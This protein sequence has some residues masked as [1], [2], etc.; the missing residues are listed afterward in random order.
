MPG[1]T[2][3]GSNDEVTCV[4]DT[5]FRLRIA[6][7]YP[8]VMNIYG[9]RGNVLALRYRCEARGIAVEVTDVT[10]GDDFDPAAVDIVVIGGGQDREQRRI[11]EDLAG[12]GA[13]LRRAV[14]DGMP[15]LAV[16]GGFQL[17]GREYVGQDGEA[18][19]GIGVFD[20]E[21]RH[22]GADVQRCIGDVVLATDEGEVVGF[23]NHGGRTYLR[24]GQA[25]FGKVVC[26]YGNNAEDGQEGARTRNAIGTYL[27][28]S[29]LPKNPA[30]TDELILAALKR[31]YGEQA[32]L[33]PL[34]DA[35][36]QAAH[37]AAVA[38]ARRSQGGQKAR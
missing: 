13:A 26:G 23:E 22:A 27:H 34:D 24:P 31:R 19:T 14:D 21:T 9:D 16:C 3:P 28:G 30:L 10:V 32:T 33:A 4:D 2:Y 15:V 25:A 7:L 37:A 36:E 20:M 18:M 38:N 5:Q 11:A 1:E 29:L 17:F 6:H 12:H 35:A 8:D